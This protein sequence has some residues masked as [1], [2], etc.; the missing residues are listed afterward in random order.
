MSVSA[1]AALGRMAHEVVGLAI[2][3]LHAL[4]A[5]VTLWADLLAPLAGPAQRTPERSAGGTVPCQT[6]EVTTSIEY[7]QL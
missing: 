1:D 5:E 6:A 2:A 4:I 3:R 7:Y